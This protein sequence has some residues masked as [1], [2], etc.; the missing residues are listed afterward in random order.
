MP[1]YS[2]IDERDGTVIELVQKMTDVHEAFAKD[3]YK[4]KRIFHIPNY[5][6]D[7][8][9][10]A[11]SAKDFNR[12]TLNKKGS[13]GDLMDLSKE[14]SEKRA[15]QAGGLDP[16]KEKFYDNYQKVRKT[17]H[18]EVRKRELKEKLKDNKFIELAE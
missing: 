1:L 5:A 11:F 2:Y 16:V 9:I 14:M 3:G 7:S 18:P 8:S 15:Q 10:N 17:K 4:L 13:L 12:A 6:I